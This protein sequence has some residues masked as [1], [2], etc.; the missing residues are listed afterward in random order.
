MGRRIL[1][2]GC[3]MLALVAGL[4]ADGQSQQAAVAKQSQE[5]VKLLDDIRAHLKDSAAIGSNQWLRG[6]LTT[7]DGS[8]AG[9]RL[10]PDVM[11]KSLEADRR[12][13]EQ[14]ATLEPKQRSAVL[15]LVNQDLVIKMAVCRRSREGMAKTI[16]LKVQTWDVTGAKKTAAPNWKVFYLSA[17]LAMVGGEGE[18]FDQLSSPTT[19]ALSPGPYVVWVQDAA[20]SRIRGPQE[21]VTLGD[22]SGNSS[23]SVTK[24]LVVTGIKK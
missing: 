24:D 13:L 1:T 23:S 5:V 3:C 8:P 16:L 2:L 18:P 11:V 6:N 9:T 17:P 21:K 4:V 15:E 20:D 14:S 10:L 22:V 12:A 7:W 19:K